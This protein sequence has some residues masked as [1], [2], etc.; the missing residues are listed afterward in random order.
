MTFPSFLKSVLFFIASIFIQFNV[1]AG[2]EYAGSIN[3]LKPLGN[4]RFF[5]EVSRYHKCQGIYSFPS[6]VQVTTRCMPG[7]AGSLSLSITNY[8]APRPISNKGP[9]AEISTT[10]TP[11]HKVQEMAEACTRVLNPNLSSNSFCRKGTQSS[12]QQLFKINY[13]VITNIL[14]CDSFLLEFAPLTS[15]GNN[16]TISSQKKYEAFFNTKSSTYSG[17]AQKNIN[18]NMVTASCIGQKQ[19]LN[20]GYFH[21]NDSIRFVPAKC[22]PGSRLNSCATSPSAYAGNGGQIIKSVVPSFDT[23]T[24]QFYYTPA[25]SGVHTF[26]VWMEQY[27]P[28]TKKL[29]ARV[30]IEQ[31][32]E[33]K[34]CTNK[35]PTFRSHSFSGLSKIDS[36]HFSMCSSN[37]FTIRDTIVDTDKDTLLVFSNFTDVFRGGSITVKKIDSITNVVEMKGKSQNRKYLNPFFFYKISDDNCNIPGLLYRSY[38]IRITSNASVSIVEGSN[39]ICRGD[40]LNLVADLG[41]TIS[42]RTLKG[43]PIVTT[44]TNQNASFKNATTREELKFWPKKTTILEMTVLTLDSCVSQ[45]CRRRDTVTIQVGSPYS[46]SIVGDTALCYKDTA[47]LQAKTDS[48]FSYSYEWKFQPS[49]PTS[50]TSDVMFSVDDNYSVLLTTTSDSGCVQTTNHSITFRTGVLDFTIDASCDTVCAGTE[51]N[52]Q[53]A[54]NLNDCGT[55]LT[56]K[57]AGSMFYGDTASS[58]TNSTSGA[59]GWPCP[60]P[61]AQTASKQQ[62]IYSFNDLK[63]MGLSTA[64]TINSIGFFMTSAA[65]TGKLV[66]VALSLKCTQDSSLT[67]AFQN[68]FTEVANLKKYKLK[69]GWNEIPFKENYRVLNNYGFIMQ[70]C[71]KST[72]GN[73]NPPFKMDVMNRSVALV[74]Y[75]SSV[76]CNS[77]VLGLGTARHQ[78][79]LRLNA[80]KNPNTNAYKYAWQP[81]SIFTDSTLRVNKTIVNSNTRVKLSITDSISKC[82]LTKEKDLLI[83]TPPTLTITNDTIA[84]KGQRINSN[85]II[86]NSINDAQFHWQPGHLFADSTLGKTSFT[87]EKDETISLTYFNTCGCAV[88]DSLRIK[89]MELPNLPVLTPNFICDNESKVTL[90]SKSG[91]G[92]FLGRAINPNTNTLDPKSTQIQTAYNKIDSILVRFADS[93]QYCGADT[94]FKIAI[95]P[96]FDTLLQVDTVYCES[97]TKIQFRTRH[98]GGVWSGPGITA[99]GQFTSFLARPGLHSIRVDSTGKCGNSATFKI[100]VHKTPAVDFSV[101]TYCIQDTCTLID[102]VKANRPGG[103]WKST[104]WPGDSSLTG[105]FNVCELGFGTFP[106]SYV[107][108]DS[109][110]KCSDSLTKNIVV[111]FNTINLTL[112]SVYTYCGSDTVRLDV[113]NNGNSVTY[114][115][116]S[117]KTSQSIN[118]T[119]GAQGIYTIEAKSTLPGNCISTKSTKINYDEN[120]LNTLE[121]SGA[122]NVMVFPNPTDD[123]LVIRLK[124]ALGKVHFAHILD[125]KGQLIDSFSF[126]GIQIEYSTIKLTQGVYYLEVSNTNGNSITKFVVQH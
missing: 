7:A 115:W 9:F 49:I 44:G 68:G 20:F 100:R 42:W 45:L 47:L 5:V 58:T 53:P 16:L 84:C 14:P 113:G 65:D 32:I 116:S 87:I 91:T 82:V 46:L 27:D 38:S 98:A 105:V 34:S 19:F 62:I 102:S 63:S 22:I 30:L 29:H 71:T 39:K 72:A 75:G 64:G 50:D 73:I 109:T 43:E 56:P 6:S 51:V 41:K 78:P 77:T 15:G 8:I 26:G 125:V 83:A 86:T 13:S 76:N 101:K 11:S 36:T 111:N 21:P 106:V 126:D 40:T 79:V 85:P 107:F 114:S 54:I 97:Q 2:H 12:T 59:L 4:N 99:S 94:S 81:G 67:I 18:L 110:N 96:Q 80:C 3:K 104:I 23:L 118:V 117:G 90:Q 88:T 61:V 52:L 33:A 112:D 69:L 66:D 24:G 92:R 103:K 120:C 57:C 121:H 95:M 119:N 89:A 93:N 108:V 74:T 31:S 1:S 17:L 35:I 28:C 123:H 10:T 48:T 60:L 37:E 70:L 25:V 124:S 122:S 55:G